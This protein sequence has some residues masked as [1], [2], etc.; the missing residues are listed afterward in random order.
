MIKQLKPHGVLKSKCQYQPDVI[1]ELT[2]PPSLS[3]CLPIT[4]PPPPSDLLHG[5]SGAGPAGRVPAQLL[6]Q[7]PGGVGDA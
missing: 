5:Q 7:R 3:L 4:A 1:E 2:L 6:R